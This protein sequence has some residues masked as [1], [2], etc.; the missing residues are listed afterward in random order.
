MH[1]RQHG[2]SP[3]PLRCMRDGS[4]WLA[5][6]LRRACFHSLDT[7][8]RGQESEPGGPAGRTG[9]RLVVPAELDGPQV[10]G[11]PADPRCPPRLCSDAP[12]CTTPLRVACARRRPLQRQS[13]HLHRSGQW[14]GGR[15]DPWDRSGMGTVRPAGLW[16]AGPV[17]APSVPA[18]WPGPVVGRGPWSPGVLGARGQCVHAPAT[19]VTGR[20]CRR[21]AAHGPRALGLSARE[22]GS[23]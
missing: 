12:H 19:L 21:V 3:G 20:R 13:L 11:R 4:L 15:L 6:V 5:V 22:R 8:S 16:G 14:P 2:G 23:G 9:A 7:H 18:A 10:P 17:A 1:P